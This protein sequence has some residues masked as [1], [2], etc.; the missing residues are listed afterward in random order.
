MTQI[1]S[2]CTRRCPD[3]CQMIAERKN[4][5]V[6]SLTG[7]PNHQ[8]TGGQLCKSQENYLTN[9]VYNENR[10]LHP[11]M[12]EQDTWSTWR[13]VS[14]N[15][16]IEDLVKKLD[17]NLQAYGPGSI[18]HIQGDGFPGISRHLNT[19]FFRATG[20]VNRITPHLEVTAGLNAMRQDFGEIQTSDPRDLLKSKLII[21]WGKNVAQSAIHLN[22]IVQQARKKGTRVLLIDP[23]YGPSIRYA[24]AHY[25]ITPGSDSALALALLWNLLKNNWHDD[26]ACAKHVENFS[27]FTSAISSLNI[28]NLCRQ[29]DL[30]P[31]V[32]ANIAHLYATTRPATI[33]IGRGLTRTPHGG[34]HVRLID[35]LSVVTGQMGEEGAGTHFHQ[36]E[37]GLNLSLLDSVK[38]S[39]EKFFSPP[40][41]LSALQQKDSPIKMVFINHCDPVLEWPGG[42]LFREFFRNI[43]TLVLMGMFLNDTSDCASHFLPVPSMLER[44][45]VV[46]SPF[47]PDISLCREVISPRKDARTEF[48]YY[49]KMARRLHLDHPVHPYWWYMRQ[50][51][52]P[53]LSSGIT[54][55]GLERGPKTHPFH[56]KTA[57]KNGTF[58][59]STGKVELITSW[60]LDLSRDRNFPLTLV[61]PTLRKWRAQTRPP[62]RQEDPLIAILH[63]DTLKKLKLAAGRK[64]VLKGPEG[65]VEVVVQD[66]P[67]QRP[68]TVVVPLGKWFY[69]G[70]NVNAVVQPLTSDLGHGTVFHGSGV[71]LR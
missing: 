60:N 46:F 17:F 36:P 22:R 34:Q 14:H 52:S 39:Q 44:Q 38:H 48:C 49:Q 6:V 4:G 7:D 2:V 65:E 5:R 26:G 20:G 15:T 53:F 3:T 59:T 21:L 8:F 58:P 12:R 18:L 35:A 61:C 23:V 71:I 45:D 63:P 62:D 55:E 31:N 57:Y 27:T 69:L 32:V 54:M 19:L 13:M 24:D 30:A 42:H 10:V 28:E 43:P 1:R 25:Q 33:V 9:V 37:Y 66:D 51:M 29:A 47:H 11:M 67:E 64:A 56:K 16:V 41:L 40:E 50:L 70:G 68:D